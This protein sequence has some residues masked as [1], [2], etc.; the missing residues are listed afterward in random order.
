[1]PEEVKH[2]HAGSNPCGSWACPRCM[3]RNSQA[4]R[5]IVYRGQAQL[6]QKLSQLSHFLLRIA[7]FRHLQ[8]EVLAQGRA[9]VLT[10]E[11]AACLQDR[12]H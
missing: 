5:V 1:M 10:A 6:P 12:D 2:L 8:V 3:C 11:Q 7:V 9:A 4:D